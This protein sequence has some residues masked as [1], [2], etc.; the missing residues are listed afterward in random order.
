MKFNEPKLIACGQKLAVTLGLVIPENIKFK[1]KINEI[2][3]EREIYL[4]AEQK[5]ITEEETAT[6]LLQHFQTLICK[7]AGVCESQLTFVEY[8]DLIQETKE[9][10]FK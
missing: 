1:Q 9:A 8:N 2:L 5:I 10:L 7:E 6:L 3:I 4:A